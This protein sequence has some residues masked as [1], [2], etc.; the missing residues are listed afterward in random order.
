MAYTFNGQ[1]MLTRIVKYLI[2]GLTIGLVA[3]LL[4]N[5]SLNFSEVILL[6]LTAA[7]TFSVLDLLSPAISVSALQGVGL[8]VGFGLMP[9]L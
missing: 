1:E 6:S 3:Y 7:A 5:K 4:P 8:G 9:F 2:L